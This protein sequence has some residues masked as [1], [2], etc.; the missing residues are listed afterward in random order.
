MADAKDD[1][2]RRYREFLDLMPLTVALA[3]LPVSEPGRY[4]NEEQIETRAYAVRHA[5]KQARQ[6]ARE[7]ATNK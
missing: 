4:Y 6:L 7:V 5:Y 3:G 2:A 1:V